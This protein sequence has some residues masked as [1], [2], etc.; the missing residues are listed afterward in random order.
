MET[1]IRFLLIFHTKWQFAQCIQINRKD[2]LRCVTV[3]NGI[4]ILKFDLN[5]RENERSSSGVAWT[6]I[7]DNGKRCDS[8]LQSKCEVRPRSACLDLDLLGLAWLGLIT[9]F[10]MVQST[11]P[12][13][14]IQVATCSRRCGPAQACARFSFDRTFFPPFSLCIPTQIVFR[15]LEHILFRLHCPSEQGW[16]KAFLMTAT[17]QK[18][19]SHVDSECTIKCSIMVNQHFLSTKSNAV[20]LLF[21]RKSVI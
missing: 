4:F 9:A 13:L 15:S 2:Y 11:I 21:E 5:C 6:W 16:H 18:R 3:S 8:E 12:N 17:L 7:E 19:R 10:W 1:V 14:W 20:P